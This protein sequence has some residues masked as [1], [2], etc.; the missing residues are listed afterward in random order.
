M[1][2]HHERRQLPYRPEQLYALVADIE[3]YPEFL[4]WV[5]GA[6]ITRRRGE[7]VW[8]DLMV[9]YKMIREKFSSKVDFNSSEMTIEVE[10]LSGPLKHLSNEWRF[11]ET[12]DGGCVIDFRVEFEFSKGFLQRL[13][14]VFFDEVI[15]RMVSSF[16][17]RAHALYGQQGRVQT[18]PYGA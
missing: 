17:A 6:R 12:P 18:V 7:V 5:A 2:Q 15:K 11:E 1:L 13:A 16:E 9:G 10:Y 4:P 3:R 14:Q 8:A